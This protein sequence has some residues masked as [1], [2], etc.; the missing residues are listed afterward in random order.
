MGWE[1]FI[2]RSKQSFISTFRAYIFFMPKSFDSFSKNYNLF[3]DQAIRIS[4]Y[5]TQTLVD[6]NTN[7]LVCK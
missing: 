3:A 4:G 7:S 5:D 6:A 2:I 1:K